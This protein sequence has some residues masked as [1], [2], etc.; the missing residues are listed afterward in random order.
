VRGRWRAEQGLR[1][2]GFGLI[3]GVDEAGRG[4]LAGP[5]VAAAVILPAGCRLPGLAD[6]K[7]ISAAQRERL[8]RLIR[9]RAVSF[10][11]GLVDAATIDEV[12]IL[13]A[14]YQAM[15]QAIEELAPP[16][17]ALLV[18]GWELPDAPV[19][20]MALVQGDRSCACIAAAS[21]LAKVERDRI[22]E[23]LD[24]LYPG[25]GFAQHK[26]YGTEEHLLQLSSR[27][28]CPEHRMSFAPVRGWS[29]RRLPLE[30]TAEEA[31]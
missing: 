1:A 18:D 12:N 27:G 20:Q 16:A 6:S 5:V 2:Q 19:P 13:Q 7:S 21:I 26:G 11:I 25:Y 23:E 22:M 28:P 3:A 15:R 10:G 24:Q 17:E 29:Q 9:K 30:A 31:P 4:P 14:T 8:C